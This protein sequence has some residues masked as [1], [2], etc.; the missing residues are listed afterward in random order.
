MAKTPQPPAD[1]NRKQPAGKTPTPPQVTQTTRR[2]RRSS[3]S[4]ANR[5][6]ERL[7][8]QQKEKRQ[9]LYTRIGIGVV[10]VALLA[11]AAWGGFKAFQG[12]QVKGDTT[13]FFGKDAFA[14]QHYE[15]AI[16]YEEVPPAGGWHNAVWQNCGFYDKYIQ[17]VNGVHSLEHGTVWIT[18]D[19]GVS[20]DV[21]SKLRDIS[22][23]PYV[24]VSPY[25]DMGNDITL[26]I[27]GHQLRLDTFDKSKVDA[28][29]RAYKN[30]QEYTPEFGAVCYG[31]T[32]ATTDVEPQTV[33]FVQND[34]NAPPIGGIRDV[35]AT[36][37][38]AALNPSPTAETGATPEPSPT[39]VVGAASNATP[40]GAT[41]AASPAASPLASPEASPAA[42]PAG[43]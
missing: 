3:A 27:W 37:T 30:K 33:P 32:S 24:L 14:A 41:P 25:P 19:P 13:E 20:D 22:D 8:Q 5:K 7:K 38:A 39:V 36:A 6:A 4:G 26:T 15:G 16:L 31:G 40:A 10:V 11:W 23:Q 42:S 43:D 34:P 28:F 2:D 18:Y 29:I 21:K 12:Y 1:R 9:W 17:N 35:D